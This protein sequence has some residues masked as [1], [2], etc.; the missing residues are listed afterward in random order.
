[1]LQELTKEVQLPQTQTQPESLQDLSLQEGQSVQESL[2]LS[3]LET[4]ELTRPR[5][6]DKMQ[7]QWQ[8]RQFEQ[9]TIQLEL[10]LKS[11][12]HLKNRSKLLAFELTR[13]RLKRPDP[14]PLAEL[15]KQH[16]LEMESQVEPRE[17][18]EPSRLSRRQHRDLAD[19]IAN[20]RPIGIPDDASYDP[21]A[22]IEVRNEMTG[23]A[24]K[25]RDIGSMYGPDGTFALRG[26]W[27]PGLYRIENRTTNSLRLTLWNE[28][29]NIAPGETW[30]FFAHSEMGRKAELIERRR[31]N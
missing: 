28:V 17:V 5:Q 10:P 23:Q 2:N 8:V 21:M 31:L 12:P 19:A 26:Q 24:W 9:P 3:L 16:L 25:F 18:S 4:G 6:F 30:R 15:W 22:V 7:V 13:L 27:P 29:H 14:K 20:P 11:E 1:M